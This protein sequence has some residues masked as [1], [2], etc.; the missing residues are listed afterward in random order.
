MNQSK[1]VEEV[2][3][4]LEIPV[5]K[6]TY[7]Y[8]T[9]TCGNLLSIKQV[10]DRFSVTY[11]ESFNLKVSNDAKPFC[12][13]SCVNL[14]YFK[15]QNEITI[16]NKQVFTNFN[17]GHIYLEYL[18]NLETEDGDF[19]IPDNPTIIEWIKDELKVELFQVLYDNGVGDMIQ[20]LGK[21]EKD[22]EI[23]RSNARSLYKTWEL[24]ELFDLRKFLYSRFHKYN[25]AVY[26]RYYAYPI[27]S[28][29]PGQKLI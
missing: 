22:L 23:S 3:D 27:N 24:T 9:D 13:N 16:K 28:K 7:D 19:L 11:S 14:N 4:P 25:T 20:R 17:S 26:G 8:C 2:I 21:A 1:I 29:A 5:C 15:E 12:T 6:S 10:F 18:S